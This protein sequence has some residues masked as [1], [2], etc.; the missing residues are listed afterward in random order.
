MTLIKVS[1]E[2]ST[3]TDYQFKES[4]YHTDPT[5][6]KLEALYNKNFLVT[7]SVR[8]RIPRIIHQV[9]LGSEFPAR[10][11]K[12]Q[13]SW[14]KHNPDWEYML[15][16][17]KEAEEF[18]FENKDLY[19]KAGNYGAK[20]DILRYAILKE[21]GGVYVDTD[22]ECLSNLNELNALCDFYTGL[23]NGEKPYLGNGI[24]GCV[25]N[26][27]I[28]NK[29]C[30]SMAIPLSKNSADEILSVTGPGKFSECVF[31]MADDTEFVNII[32]PVTYFYPFPNNM[33]HIQKERLKMKFCRKESIA[34]H[35]WEVSW[36]NTSQLKG[37]LSRILRYVPSSYKIALKKFGIRYVFFKKA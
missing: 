32:F 4:T 5:W 37:I 31:A 11:K 24:I 8:E 34:I 3:A 16:T 10:Y 27:P 25:P 17:N 36:K 7:G 14:L 9:W 23:I 18:T 35:H 22:F 28:I 30:D 13:K 20:S 19:Y 21:Y 33:L 1:F 29:L 2:E 6:K 26:H 12:W 15:W